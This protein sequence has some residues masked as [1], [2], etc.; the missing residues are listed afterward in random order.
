MKWGVSV[1]GSEG[2]RQ[3]RTRGRASRGYIP[4]QHVPAQPGSASGGVDSKRRSFRG[5][6]DPQP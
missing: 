3:L 5:T 2:W 4:R 6:S 1:L